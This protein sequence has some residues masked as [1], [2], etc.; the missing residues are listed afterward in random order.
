[1]ALWDVFISYSRKDSD[2][3]DRYVRELTAAG[4]TIWLDREPR[5]GMPTVLPLKLAHGIAESSL[6]VLFLSD[7]AAASPWVP[8]E[9]NAF[10]KKCWGLWDDGVL[11]CV[12]VVQFPETTFDLQRLGRHPWCHYPKRPME[13]FS[14]QPIDHEQGARETV[15]FASTNIPK[16]RAHAE[17][18]LASIDRLDTATRFW[19]GALPLQLSHW[20]IELLPYVLSRFNAY[21]PTVAS[22]ITVDEPFATAVMEVI[23]LATQG[24]QGTSLAVIYS[25]AIAAAHGGTYASLDDRVDDEKT[26]LFKAPFRSQVMSTGDPVDML[27]GVARDRNIASAL[28]YAYT[29]IRPFAWGQGSRDALDLTTLISLGYCLLRWDWEAIEV[30]ET[31]EEMLN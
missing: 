14:S 21:L 19:K 25:E 12:L 10:L 18:N 5:A 16:L 30:L 13:L 11:P 2:I 23:D 8:Q 7:S 15:L 31:L 29:L 24:T 9:V 4:V 3:V 17:K 27:C 28:K 26:R 20:D 22:D 1:M 6:L